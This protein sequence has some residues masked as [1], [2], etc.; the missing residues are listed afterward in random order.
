MNKKWYKFKGQYFDLE[1]PITSNYLT[2]TILEDK[3]LEKL[4]KKIEN[5]K[6]SII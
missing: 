2:I 3:I 4:N 6:Y 5:I 1:Y